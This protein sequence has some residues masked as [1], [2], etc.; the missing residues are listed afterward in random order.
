M[1]PLIYLDSSAITK[2]YIKEKG[3]ETIDVIFDASEIEKVKLSFSMWNIGEII[4]VFDQYHRRNWIT[5]E[6]FREATRKFLIELQKLYKLK[7]LQLIPVNS[8]ILVQSFPLITKYHMYQADVL[9]AVSFK[10]ANAD[11]FISADKKLLTT[12]KIL[13]KNSF[14][15]E[16]EE[17]SIQEAIIS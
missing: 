1:I 17:I 11:I 9:Q 3:T 8:N 12:M 14:N 7:T 4:G 2:R 16:T 10:A 15:I 6:E 5:E 13:H